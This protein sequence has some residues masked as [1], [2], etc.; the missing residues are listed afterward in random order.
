MVQ[1][2]YS[3]RQIHKTKSQRKEEYIYH[4]RIYVTRE[5]VGI[6]EARGVGMGIKVKGN[7]IKQT[8]H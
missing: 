5:G 1:K 4:L 6:E 2:I 8:Q 7:K 3:R